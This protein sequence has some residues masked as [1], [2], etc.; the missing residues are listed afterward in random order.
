M[1]RNDFFHSNC[2]E[3]SVD[4]FLRQESINEIKEYSE[5]TLKSATG[6]SFT[7][8]RNMSTADLQNVIYTMD[9]YCEACAWDF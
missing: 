4:D 7:D 2:R 8:L 6:L 3:V 9:N 5:D 1:S